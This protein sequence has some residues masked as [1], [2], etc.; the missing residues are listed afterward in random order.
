ML[1]HASGFAAFGYEVTLMRRYQELAREGASWWIVFAPNEAKG[2]RA[3]EVVKGYG[4]LMAEKYHNLV[5]EDL[6]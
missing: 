3:A 2:Q 5:I 1:Q 4:A 6:I